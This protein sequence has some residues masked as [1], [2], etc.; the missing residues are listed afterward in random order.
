MSKKEEVKKPKKVVPIIERHNQSFNFNTLIGKE[1]TIYHPNPGWNSRTGIV[2]KILVKD[3]LVE[4]I[5]PAENGKEYKYKVNMP[6]YCLTF[7]G[8]R[9]PDFPPDLPKEVI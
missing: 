6:S 3:V 5:L 8:K 2:R 9:L 1:V 4:V 7:N